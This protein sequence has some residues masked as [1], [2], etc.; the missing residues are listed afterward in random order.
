MVGRVEAFASRLA[1]FERGCPKSVSILK[2]F[3]FLERRANVDIAIQHVFERIDEA[4]LLKRIESP[5]SI[6]QRNPLGQIRKKMREVEISLRS[7]MDFHTLE[8]PVS[9]FV[10]G[11]GLCLL[12]SSLLLLPPSFVLDLALIGRILIGS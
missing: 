6:R 12:C 11:D 4:T 10:E 9:V 3:E 2:R 5:N 1:S 7:Q 8:I